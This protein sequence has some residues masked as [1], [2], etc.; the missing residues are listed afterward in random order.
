[1]YLWE[2]TSLTLLFPF[3]S[4][5]SWMFHLEGNYRTCAKSTHMLLPTPICYNICKCQNLKT[6]LRQLF[7]FEQTMGCNSEIHLAFIRVCSP[8][9]TFLMICLLLM[10]IYSSENIL[11]TL[12]HR[13]I[14]WTWSWSWSMTDQLAWN[15]HT[16]TRVH[17]MTD[18][19]ISISFVP[20]WTGTGFAQFLNPGLSLTGFWDHIQS[21][22]MMN[23][24]PGNAY[25]RSSSL[26]LKPLCCCV[27]DFVQSYFYM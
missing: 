23:A 25:H 5:V 17:V 8:K 7:T 11:S 16:I 2:P 15:W 12:H 14:P 10:A 9:G 6:F 4:T 22:I 3:A 21:L 13:F 20:V 18:H 19:I 1:M 27:R 26:L 24:G